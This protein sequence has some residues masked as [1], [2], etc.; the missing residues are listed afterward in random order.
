[1]LRAI[2]AI[3]LPCL[4][5]CSIIFFSSSNLARAIAF[6]F[7]MLATAFLIPATTLGLSSTYLACAFLDRSFSKTTVFFERSLYN[8]V[9]LAIACL[10]SALTKM[11]MAGATRCRSD[12]MMTT[13]T[14]RFRGFCVH[15]DPTLWAT[16]SF[17]TNVLHSVGMA[18]YFHWARAYM[19]KA[20]VALQ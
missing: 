8:T 11:F 1:M 20:A 3:S 5:Q 7:L 15:D 9:A 13:S 6:A 16:P 14:G 4:M 17:P 18:A 2:V 10:Y 12:T 19:T